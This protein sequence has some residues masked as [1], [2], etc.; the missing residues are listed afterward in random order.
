MMSWQ[1]D[2]FLL[3]S[4]NQIKPRYVYWI[5]AK[6]VL[7]Y[8]HVMDWDTPSKAWWIHWWL[9]KTEDIVDKKSTFGCCCSLGSALTSWLRQK[10]KFVDLSTTKDEYIIA[11]MASYEGVWLRK[12]FGEMFE[13]V[14]NTTVIYCYNKSRE[15]CVPWQVQA[16]WDQISL[17]M[18]YDAQRST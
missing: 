8:L 11:S 17:Y 7:R 13:Q 14:L 2:E 5:V 15:S 1:S 9:T 18:W 3:C 10:Q 16:Y 6:Y 12:L 4:M